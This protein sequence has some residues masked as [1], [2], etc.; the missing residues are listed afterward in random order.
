MIRPSGF[1]D[2]MPSFKPGDLVTFIEGDSWVF[3]TKA[4]QE[5]KEPPVG[6]VISTFDEVGMRVFWSTGEITMEWRSQLQLYSVYKE[7][8]EREKDI[9]Q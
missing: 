6:I 1:N 3:I 5:A 4:G 7:Q 8:K 9:E 2:T